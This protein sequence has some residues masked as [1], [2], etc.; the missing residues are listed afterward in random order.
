M[1]APLPVD[2]LTQFR[3]LHDVEAGRTLTTTDAVQ[4]HQR[5]RRLSNI[6]VCIM[7]VY[8]PPW[9]LKYLFELLQSLQFARQA[10]QTATS[11]THQAHNGAV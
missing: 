1:A 3:V 11:P 4:T 10:T 5:G 9:S 6:D 8:R 7:L 2:G